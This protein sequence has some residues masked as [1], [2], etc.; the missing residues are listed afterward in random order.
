MLAPVS[1]VDLGK[2]ADDAGAKRQKRLDAR[3]ALTNALHDEKDAVALLEGSMRKDMAYA[4]TVDATEADYVAAGFQMRAAPVHHKGDL[5]A[6]ASVHASPGDA[7]GQVDLVWPPVPRARVY[8]I[9]IAA[10]AEGPFAH[11]DL[12]TESRTRL[13]GQKTGAK[14][15][16]RVRPIG[17]NNHSGPP[18][19]PVGI[20][21]P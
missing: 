4:E 5:A 12:S 15:Y 17:A 9:E 3:L 18:S 20:V 1:P 14:M 19:A 6:V 21:V 16:Y 11:E 13:E 2:Q 10:G 7:P 8:E